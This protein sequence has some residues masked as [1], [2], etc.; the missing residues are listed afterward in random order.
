MTDYKPANICE[1][2][3]DLGRWYGEIEGSRTEPSTARAHVEFT[4]TVD[5][6]LQLLKAD[7]LDGIVDGIGGCYSERL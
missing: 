2:M 5:T 7:I 4:K 6:V 1:I 3:Y